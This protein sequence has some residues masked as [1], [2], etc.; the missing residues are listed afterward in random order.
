MIRVELSDVEAAMRSYRRAAKDLAQEL[1]RQ[2][3]SGSYQ[4]YTL[5][6]PPLLRPRHWNRKN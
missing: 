5:P 1:L 4:T 6:R 2:W 3:R